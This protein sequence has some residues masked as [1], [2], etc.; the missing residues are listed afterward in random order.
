MAISW[1]PSLA[2]GVPEID[3]QH[4]ELF[5]RLDRL[6]EGARSGKSADEVGRLL[7]Y[8]GEYVVEHFGAEE[9]LMKARRYPG[10][11][12][13]QAEHERFSVEFSAL[14]RE[15]LADG[16]TLLLIVRVNARVTA[17]LR[18]HI[19]RTDRAFGAFLAA[20]PGGTAVVETPART[21]TSAS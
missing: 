5:D 19:Y 12:D 13:H 14:L 17:W 9:A 6:L 2:I 15:Y 10:L 18:E 16:A 1:D 3:A 4:A 7:G 8:L 20:T 21:R 11:A